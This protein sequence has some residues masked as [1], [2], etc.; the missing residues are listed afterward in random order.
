[1]SSRDWRSGAAYDDLEEL[2]L[3]GLAWEYL[4]RNPDYIAEYRDV[5]NEPAGTAEVKQT[6]RSWGL[7]FRGRPEPPS[8]DRACILGYAILVRHNRNCA[9]QRVAGS[10]EFKHRMAAAAG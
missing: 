5:V 7:R 3:R 6:C 9:P 10:T 1:M 2:N 4:R 8:D